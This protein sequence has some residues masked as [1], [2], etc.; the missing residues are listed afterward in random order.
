MPIVKEW[1]L[2]K[3]HY[4][5]DV[6]A[7]EGAT[8]QA[9]RDTAKTPHEDC[10]EWI[11]LARRGEPGRSPHVK[12]TYSAERDY[13]ELDIV[14]RNG[15]SFIAK[16]STPRPFDGDGGQDWQ[17]LTMPGKKGPQ[18]DP[19]P[20]GDK[21]ERGEPGPAGS[22]IAAWEVDP[23]NYSATAVMS[24]GM[25]AGTLDLRPLFERFLAELSQ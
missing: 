9:Q 22:I 14:V 8:W 16:V 21:G 15:G 4:R 12:G 17:C 11:C 10:E 25:R 18:G 5:G 19:G 3:V 7:H 6:V 20:H 13:A 23:T 24:D 1:R 2:D